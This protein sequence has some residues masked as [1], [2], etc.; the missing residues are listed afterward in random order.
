MRIP[1]LGWPHD[2]TSVHKNIAFELATCISMEFKRDLLN[3]FSSVQ[4]RYA[5]VLGD[6]SGSA[7]TPQ[8]LIMA[9]SPQ[10]EIGRAKSVTTGSRSFWLTIIAVRRFLA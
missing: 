5:K 7:S 9:N 1:P 6:S 3:E 2:G 10:L 8:N 4:L